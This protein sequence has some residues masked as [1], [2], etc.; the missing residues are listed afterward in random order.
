MSDYLGFPKSGIDKKKLVS[1]IKTLKKIT[2]FIAN[3][4]VKILPF[5]ILF[6]GPK[7]VPLNMPK[8]YYK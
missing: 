6:E 5:N 1:V 2:P 3:D 4:Y 7:E 8:D